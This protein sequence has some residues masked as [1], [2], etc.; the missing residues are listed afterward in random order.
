MIEGL[1]EILTKRRS[2]A[3]FKLIDVHPVT[4]ILGESISSINMWNIVNL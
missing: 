2:L 3:F 4:N 1:L